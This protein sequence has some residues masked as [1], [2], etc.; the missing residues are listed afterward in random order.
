LEKG[1]EMKTDETFITRWL[2]PGKTFLSQ[3]SLLTNEQW[4]KKEKKRI[5]GTKIIE[6]EGLLALVKEKKKGGK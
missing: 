5:R 6:K 1:E 4:L 3:Y 2:V